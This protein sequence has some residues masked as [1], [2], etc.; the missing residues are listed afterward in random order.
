M[1]KHETSTKYMNNVLCVISA[2]YE[3]MIKNWYEFVSNIFDSS[4]STSAS[5]STPILQADGLTEESRYS[6]FGARKVDY[7]ETV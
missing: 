6:Q 7:R 3:P 2:M 5:S 1:Q 4:T